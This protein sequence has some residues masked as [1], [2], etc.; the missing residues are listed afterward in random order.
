MR[1]PDA[2]LDDAVE[3]L[4]SAIRR[5]EK[6]QDL[7]VDIGL[8]PTA[9]P[10]AIME[11]AGKIADELGEAIKEVLKASSS[12]KKVFYG[13]FF[14]ATDKVLDM[15][16]WNDEKGL[17]E[18]YD[19]VLDKGRLHLTIKELNNL[20]QEAFFDLWYEIEKLLRVESSEARKA[21]NRRPREG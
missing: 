21:C 19:L 3:K 9:H 8:H 18:E 2:V 6:A 14:K 20:I 10:F 5:M 13:V 15:E 1:R 7:A 17:A 11:E 16:K 4:R 12:L